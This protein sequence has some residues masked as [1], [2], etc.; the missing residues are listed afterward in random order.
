MAFRFNCTLEGYEYRNQ[1]SGLSN[2]TGRRWLSLIVED[3]ADGSQLDIG[4]P[5]DLISDVDAMELKKGDML[6]IPV[7]AVSAKDYSFVRLTALPTVYDADG[8]VY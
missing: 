3:A 2:N 5:N 6:N 8:V 4:V 7:V 1:R